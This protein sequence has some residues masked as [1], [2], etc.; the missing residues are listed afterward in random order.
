MVCKIVDC[1]GFHAYNVLVV[2]KR[3]QYLNNRL[4]E[5]IYSI[6]SIEA[7]YAVDVIFQQ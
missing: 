1:A 6:K 7:L 4:D 3:T 2:A 5:K